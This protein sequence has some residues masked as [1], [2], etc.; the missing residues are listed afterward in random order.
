MKTSEAKR[1]LSRYDTNAKVCVL[2]WEQADEI[3]RMVTELEHQNRN[4]EA[5]Q[6]RNRELR[7]VINEMQEEY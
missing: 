5:I 3:K 6:Y 2:T 4:V 1:L 7:E